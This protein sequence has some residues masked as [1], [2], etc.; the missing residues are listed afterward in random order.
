M[1][2]HYKDILARI[3]ESPRWFDEQGVPRYCPF[4]PGAIAN[5]YAHECALLEIA[6]QG[7]GKSF[8]VAIDQKGANEAIAMPGQNVPWQK[9][10]DLIRSQKIE[11][12]D[13]PNVECCGD[14]PSMTSVTK[15]VLEYWYRWEETY[16]EPGS[17]VVL[18]RARSMDWK[19]D[20]RL[21]IEIKSIDE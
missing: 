18:V 9:L 10:A 15:R 4:T 13:P 19:R 7:C 17:A 5:I 1:F 21:E 12:S 16:T 3:A 20:P 6:C 11:Y 8:I 2:Q 14:G